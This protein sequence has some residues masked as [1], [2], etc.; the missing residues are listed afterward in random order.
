MFLAA[1]LSLEPEKQGGGNIK[2]ICWCQGM[3]LCRCN[4]SVSLSF[5]DVV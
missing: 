4:D 3:S 5:T 2:L 1:L